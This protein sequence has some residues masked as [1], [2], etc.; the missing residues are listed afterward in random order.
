MSIN[1][2]LPPSELFEIEKRTEIKH[3]ETLKR[4]SFIVRRNLTELK[5]ISEL[6]KNLQSLSLIIHQFKQVDLEDYKIIAQ[7]LRSLTSLTLDHCEGETLKISQIFSTRCHKLKSIN[8][9]NI[10]LDPIVP[11]IEALKDRHLLSLELYYMMRTGSNSHEQLSF[12][13]KGMRA[14]NKLP[15]LLHYNEGPVNKHKADNV[16]YQFPYNLPSKGKES[17]VIRLNL[18]FSKDTNFDEVLK[19]CLASNNVQSLYLEPKPNNEGL[20]ELNLEVCKKIAISFPELSFIKIHFMANYLEILPIFT[21]HCKKLVKVTL[22]ARPDDKME[23]IVNM[24][25]DCGQNI[26]SFRL[27]DAYS[28]YQI[29]A[30]WRNRLIL[31]LPKLKFINGEYIDSPT[32]DNIKKIQS[33][34]TDVSFTFSKTRFYNIESKGRV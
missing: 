8:I 11:I 14:L 22:A 20:R 26:Q 33:K 27:I 4:C 18:Q 19:A 16:L 21:E 24:L 17:E 32:I 9:D 3:P 31:S 6:C 23:A 10:Y 12:E 1:S 7:N 15:D 30:Q 34:I 29:T 2:A 5:T 25:I 13:S 28:S